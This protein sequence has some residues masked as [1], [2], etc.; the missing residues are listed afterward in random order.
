MKGLPADTD[1][2]V[3]GASVAGLRAAVELA[4]A[5][6]VL[7]LNKKEIPNFSAVDAKSQASWLSET[8]ASAMATPIA[9]PKARCETSCTLSESFGRITASVV[10][11]ST[12]MCQ[13]GK[14]N[15]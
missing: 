2:I 9:V 3:I 12:T 10:I 6:R 7:V 13:A 15:R 1:Y 14:V 11:Q 4:A 5:G 8:I